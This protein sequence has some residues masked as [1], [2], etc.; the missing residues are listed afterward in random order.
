MTTPAPGS[1]T[2]LKY[3]FEDGYAVEVHGIRLDEAHEKYVAMYSI[4]NVD[5]EEIYEGEVTIKP[6]AFTETPNFYAVLCAVIY[7]LRQDRR[8]HVNPGRYTSQGDG[9][10]RLAD[11]RV[12]LWLGTSEE[13]MLDLALT[14]IAGTTRRGRSYWEHGKWCRAVGA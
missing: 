4:L 2:D 12:R 3:T 1:N 10:I 14:E 11:E 7:T 9:T 13:S 6:D 8:R 5:D